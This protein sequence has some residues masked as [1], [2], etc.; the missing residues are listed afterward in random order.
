MLTLP[1]SDPR[2][3]C[4]GVWHFMLPEHQGVSHLGLTPRLHSCFLT[5]GP[6]GRGPPLSQLWGPSAAPH[7]TSHQQPHLYDFSEGLEAFKLLPIHLPQGPQSL[8]ESKAIF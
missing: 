7:A 4:L 8:K 2:I 3:P 5:P 1:S 6:M